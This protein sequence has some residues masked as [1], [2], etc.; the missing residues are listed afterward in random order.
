MSL[1]HVRLGS[2]HRVREDPNAREY[3]VRRRIVHP[4]YETNDLFDVA[5][6]E[7]DGEA[8]MSGTIQ[9]LCLPEPN[10]NTTYHRQCY[11]AGW[12]KRVK[13]PSWWGFSGGECK[14]D[15]RV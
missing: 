7:L 2:I 4:S 9:P 12:G 3:S 8:E 6:L 14:S 11:V 1:L 10:S 15:G 5:L 13:L